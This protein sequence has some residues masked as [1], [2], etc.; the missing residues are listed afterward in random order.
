MP[1]HS[2]I[3]LGDSLTEWFDWQARFPSYRVANLGIAGET[4]EGLLGRL[5]RVR[6]RINDG[7]AVFLMTGINNIAMGHRDIL[8]AYR[9]VASRLRGDFPKAVLVVQ[10]VL[11]VNLPGTDNSVILRI[12]ERL[13]RSAAEFKARYLDLYT[14]FT[15]R[16]GEPRP[17]YLLDDG[18]HVSAEG[19]RAWADEVEKYLEREGLR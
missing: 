19:Y 10:S 4:V 2:L 12:N 11:P 18:V 3:F 6:T 14:V 8:P 7:D 13:E 17:G 1:P 5:D 16:R 15:D 9:E